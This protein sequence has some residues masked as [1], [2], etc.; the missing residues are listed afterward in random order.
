MKLP[1]GIDGSMKSLE[2]VL[3]GIARNEP[4]RNSKSLVIDN[5]R[6]ANGNAG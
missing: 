5:Q 6:F 1:D 2:F 4:A 3:D